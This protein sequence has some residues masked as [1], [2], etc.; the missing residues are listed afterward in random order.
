[1]NLTKRPVAAKGKKCK[2]CKEQFTPTRPLQSCCSVPCAIKH[3]QVA[4]EKKERLEHR[5]AKEKL[6][7][8]ADWM[9]EAQ[10]SFNHYI[11]AR[12]K[13]KGYGCISCGT[14]QGK[15]NCGHYRSVGSSPELRFN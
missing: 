7:S 13:S 5:V 15:E 9:R 1:M 3:S 10:Q 4:K 8:R 12:D 11:R 6:K 2:V 14:F